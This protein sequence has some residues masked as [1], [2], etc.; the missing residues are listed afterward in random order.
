M[1]CSATYS[2]SHAPDGERLS[3]ERALERITNAA[4]FR[5][6]HR[7]PFL[8]N[9]LEHQL[10]GSEEADDGIWSICFG[11]VLLGKIDERDMIAG[12]SSLAS[13]PHP[14]GGVPHPPSV[15]GYLSPRLLT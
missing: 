11:T 6:H 4:T 9:P 5:L 14:R 3:C 13:P 2:S 1:P 8:A 12:D 7:L 15:R 10:I